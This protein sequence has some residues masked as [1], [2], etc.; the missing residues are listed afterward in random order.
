MFLFDGYVH[1]ISV[2]DRPDSLVSHIINPRLFA[3]YA[4]LIQDADLF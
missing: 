3:F 4:K 2:L 1:K